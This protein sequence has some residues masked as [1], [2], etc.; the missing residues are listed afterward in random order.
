MFKSDYH[1][2]DYA[3][4]INNSRRMLE[5]V[6][7]GKLNSISIIPNM[8]CFDSCIS[9]LNDLLSSSDINPDISIHLNIIDGI[10]LSSPEGKEYFQNSWIHFF[11]ISL[12]PGKRRSAVRAELCEEF[13][14]QITRCLDAIE[15]L[16]GI[17]LDSHV[18]THMIPVVF[19]AMCD[20]IAGLGLE[21]RIRF[22]RNCREP[23]IPFITT[24][25]IAGTLSFVNILKNLILN[26]L[27]VRVSCRL[28]S[29]GI[30]DSCLFGLVFSG[31]MDDKR[32]KKLSPRMEHFASGKDR[33]LE[34]LC[35]PGIVL[36]SELMPEHSK[37]SAFI[38]S[39]N[40]DLEYEMITSR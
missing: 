25:G 17:R 40:R 8:S 6:K 34:I 32:V 20:A 30:P 18:H 4:S 27:S 14:L 33:Y 23:L 29:M 7:T 19:D 26:I 10:K 22:I 35:H 2:D 36:S 21:N 38:T 9:L 16:E 11:L 24:H 12:I 28:R 37:D 5:L 3:Y 1:G 39:P 31:S 13:M 15:K